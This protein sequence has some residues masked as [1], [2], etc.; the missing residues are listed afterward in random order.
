M[1]HKSTSRLFSLC[2]V[3]LTLVGCVRA[4]F[5][6]TSQPDAPP[7]VDQGNPDHPIVDYSRKDGPQ[8]EAK[9]SDVSPGDS[10][11]KDAAP[12]DVS[13]LDAPSAEGPGPDADVAEKWTTV[14]AGTFSMGSPLVGECG[15]QHETLHQVTLNHDFEI[16]ATEVTQ[17]QFETLM[18]YRPLGVNPCDRCPVAWLT[19]DEAVAYCN[20]LSYGKT[21]KE[22]YQCSDVGTSSVSCIVAPAYDGTNKSIYACPG[23]RLPTDAE[24][25]YAY[26]AGTSTPLYEGTI[27]PAACGSCSEVDV[28]TTKIAWY[29]ANSG[30]AVHEVGQK[31]PNA[32]ALYDMAGNVWEWIHDWYQADLGPAARTDP[33]GPA[34]GSQRIMR[35]GTYHLFPWTLQGSVR[36]GFSPAA[37]ETRLGFR[38]VRTLNP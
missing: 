18:T 20:I 2:A 38:C 22:C 31:A 35:G 30:G 17:K 25:E 3:I 6:Q 29:C 34:T 5:N 12:P 32:W 19:W 1:Q 37:R 13:R 11:K 8:R 15:P 14:T 33:W 16:S 9:L 4:G 24:W 21:L 27:N 7:P 28:A 36:I 10:P 23:Y 26:R